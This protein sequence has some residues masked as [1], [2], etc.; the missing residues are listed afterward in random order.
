MV[1]LD[2]MEETLPR[3]STL[4]QLLDKIVLDVLFPNARSRSDQ[5]PHKRVGYALGRS[6]AVG[7]RFREQ[8]WAWDPAETESEQSAG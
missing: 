4:S 5:R 1:L 7:E 8:G 2:E 6:V 3:K